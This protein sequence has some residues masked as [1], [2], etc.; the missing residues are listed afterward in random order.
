MDNGFIRYKVWQNQTSFGECQPTQHD[1][2][3]IN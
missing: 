1:G 3:F 2:S